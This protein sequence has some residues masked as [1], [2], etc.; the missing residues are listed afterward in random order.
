MND[1]RH[2]DDGPASYLLGRR[3]VL[4]RRWLRAMRTHM[5]IRPVT[6]EAVKG[7]VNQLPDIFSELCAVLRGGDPDGQSGSRA[8]RDARAHAQERWRQGFALDELYFE[9]ALLERCV[10][11]CVREYFAIVASRDGQ[12]ELH[13]TIET[14]F[15]DTIRSAMR[16]YQS[17]SDR[18]VSDAL[19]ERDAAHQARR[20]SEERQRM[21]ADAAGLGIFEWD[22]VTDGAVWENARMFDILG[23]PLEL[24]PLGLRDFARLLA[25][26]AESERLQEIISDATDS[27]GGVSAVFRVRRRGAPEPVAIE[28]SARYMSDASGNR[29]LVGTIA[30]ITRRIEG[31][32]ALKEADRRKDVFLATLAHELRNPLAPV[33]NAAHL[34]QRT[35]LP[36][37]QLRWIREMIERHAKHLADLVDDLLDLSR[38][39]AGKVRL[40]E[41][42]FDIRTAIQRA[43]EINA[44]AAAARRHRLHTPRLDHISAIWVKGD[45]TR[46]TQIVSNLLDNAIKYTP[47]GGEIR[48][49]LDRRERVVLVVVEDNGTGMDPAS[50]QSMFELFNQ[51]TPDGESGKAGLG[52]GLSL[53]RSLVAMHGG[54]VYATSEGRGRGSRFYVEL[55]ACD[56]PEMSGAQDSQASAQSI[57][58][59]NV[60]IVDDNFDAAESLAAI[61]GEIHRVRTAANGEDAL[62]L[63]DASPPDIVVLD[64]S[65][66]DVS[67]YEIAQRLL[68]K[69]KCNG[70]ITLI[71]LTGHGQPEDRERTRQAGFDHHLVKPVPPQE[72]LKLLNAIAG[73]R[74]MRLPDGGS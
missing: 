9:L 55:P 17:Q 47:V 20:R 57:P 65:L 35:N 54:A 72:L 52:I 15:S 27:A 13:E 34:L 53:A 51:E 46:I 59:L 11:R 49:T 14:F 24:G 43:I 64:L 21:A 5:H 58:V 23:Q 48:L 38:I 1:V 22:P 26:P 2:T 7:L 68:R 67:G 41:E 25:V 66:P 42:V 69:E 29:K 36:Q 39:S 19:A 18:R 31:E 71:A 16:Q 32:E 70:W 37:S 63:A 62:K 61:I 40:R 74:A 28:V 4:T 45:L 73:R 12:T 60:M 50:I 56:E 44:P 10:Q 33:I 30:D 8:R 3:F 6:R